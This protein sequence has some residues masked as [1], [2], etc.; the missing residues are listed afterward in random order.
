MEKEKKVVEANTTEKEGSKFGWGVLGF[1][2]PLV[3]L[4]LFL[5]WLKDKK[6]AAKAAGIGALIGFILNVI[7]TVFAFTGVISI[8]TLAGE[9]VIDVKNK[10]KT[11]EKKKDDKD[12]IT[13]DKT[14]KEES[15]NTNEST[16]ADPND[17]CSVKATAG[18]KAYLY[19]FNYSDSCET[20]NVI[21][22]NNN[23]LFK[24]K[25]NKLVLN[26]NIE[27]FNK[28]FYKVDNTLI[29]YSTL[30][31]P[32]YCY[33]YVYNL[34]DNTGFEIKSNIEKGDIVVPMIN[35]IEIN[36]SKDLVVYISNNYSASFESV[37]NDPRAI[38]ILKVRSC[39]ITHYDYEGS[40][41]IDDALKEYGLDNFA[42]M[43]AYKYKNTNG[44]IKNNP[45]SEVKETIK[46]FSWGVAEGCLRQHGLIQ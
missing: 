32:G 46:D 13:K 31:S 12:T 4:I 39:E 18:D 40:T 2:F 23:I 37:M 11:V 7:V 35:G 38:V 14:N 20:T 28:S 10:T 15:K 45:T 24:I 29:F 5:V 1:F 43:K 22:D 27:N 25:N 42:T 3:G 36:D 6:K 33:V 16:K 8:F 9:P 26:N 19:N 30:C 44:S 34:N 21:D 41:N 17:A